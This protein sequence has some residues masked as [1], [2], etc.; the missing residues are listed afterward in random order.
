MVH[1]LRHMVVIAASLL[2]PAGAAAGDAPAIS[3]ASDPAQAGMLD[4]APLAPGFVPDMRYAGSDN[5]TGRPVPGYEAPRCYLHAA[6]AQ[7]LARVQRR[8]QAQGHALRLYD[9]YRPVRAVQSFMR[10]VDD[11][12]DQLAKARYYPNIDKGLLVEQGYIAAQSGHSRGAT[13]DLGLLD[14]RGGTCVER[15]M[16][17]GFDRFDPLAHTDSTEITPSQRRNRQRLLEAMRAE[18]FANYPMEWWHYTF[19]PEPTPGTAYDFPV[20]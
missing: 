18:G 6:A 14:C 11:P 12:A 3:P 16:G 10:W 20:R 13:V 8:L 9:C 1:P 15:D 4:V 5:F 19:Q 7:A 17:T 2:I